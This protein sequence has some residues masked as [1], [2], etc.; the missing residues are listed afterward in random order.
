M[1]LKY[2]INNEFIEQ[3]E[4]CYEKEAHHKAVSGLETFGGEPIMVSSSSDNS[5]KVSRLTIQT[6]VFY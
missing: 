1:L 4:I 3:E 2:Q 5:L 6:S